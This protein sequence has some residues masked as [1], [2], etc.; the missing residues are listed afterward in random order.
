VQ[1]YE[2]NLEMRII[3]Y[4]HPAFNSFSKAGLLLQAEFSSYQGYY[5]IY[6]FLVNKNFQYT[7][8]K[9]YNIN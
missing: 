4:F 3:F 5:F 7:D 2:N 6:I 8:N 1:R 9:I